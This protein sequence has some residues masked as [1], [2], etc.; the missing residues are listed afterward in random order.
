LSMDTDPAALNA[1][2][3]GELKRWTAFFQESGFK[4]Q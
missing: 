3:A 4:P 2:I 1:F